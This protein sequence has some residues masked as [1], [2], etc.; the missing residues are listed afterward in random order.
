M[1]ELIVVYAVRHALVRHDLETSYTTRSFL[2]HNWKTLSEKTRCK[3]LA[4]IGLALHDDGQQLNGVRY[5]IWKDFLEQQKVA[6]HS[7]PRQ[8]S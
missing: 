3:I 5:V 1:N 8:P 7:E 4:D 2:E 6:L